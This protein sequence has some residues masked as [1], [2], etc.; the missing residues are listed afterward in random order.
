MTRIKKYTKEYYA[1]L[2]NLQKM[3]IA[4]MLEDKGY[5]LPT[6][7]E[8]HL[9][10]D[11]VLMINKLLEYGLKIVLC[12]SHHFWNRNGKYFNVWIGINGKGFYYHIKDF[13]DVNVSHIHTCVVRFLKKQHDL[14]ELGSLKSLN[15]PHQV[16]CGK[17]NGTGYLKHYSHVFGV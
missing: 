9:D 4:K 1:N 16:K 6:T 15:I 7:S 10:N 12:S 5:Y 17:C 3:G 13:Y 11:Q 8:L 2:E 14:G